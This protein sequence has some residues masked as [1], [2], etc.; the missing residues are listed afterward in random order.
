[1]NKLLLSSFISSFL[2]FGT[3]AQ[4]CKIKT[5]PYTLHFENTPKDFWILGDSALTISAQANSNLFI[6]PDGLYN[7]N[8]APKLLFRPDSDFIFTAKIK[9]DFKSKW[10]AGA[11]LIYNDNKHFAKFCFESDFT[12]QPR[13]VTVVCNETSDDCNSMPISTDEVSF[14]ITGSSKNKI[15]SFYYLNNAGCWYPIRMFKLDKAD[16]IQIG[17][18]AQSP[19]GNECVVYFS[20]ISF[21]Q[22]KVGNIWLGD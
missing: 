16:N 4:E 7:N 11:L 18:S 8:T 14:R 10:D 22:R 17:F 5:I 20:E 13:I 12:N 21:M 9:L 6:S 2:Y 1:M 19:N 3:F 15:F